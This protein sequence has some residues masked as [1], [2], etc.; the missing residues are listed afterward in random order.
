MSQF[1]TSRSKATAYQVE[2]T[3]PSG[4]RIIADEPQSQGGGDTGLSPNELLAAA[5]ATCTNVTLRMYAARK[6]WD[7]GEITVKVSVVQ[8]APDQTEFQRRISFAA[9]LTEE[10]RDRMLAIANK[11]PVH[12]LLEGQ[13]LVQSELDAGSN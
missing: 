11:C 13:V 4:N 12:R 1:I 7:T 10:Q 6:S 9:E 2:I 8:K 3:S 5:L